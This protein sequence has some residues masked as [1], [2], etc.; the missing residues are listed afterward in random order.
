MRT[1]YCNM[2]FLVDSATMFNIYFKVWMFVVVI[3]F[4]ST[5]TVWGVAKQG[6]DGKKINLF[7]TY[8]YGDKIC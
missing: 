4:L 8:C 5:Q 7:F 2:P 1:V 3:F 6:K